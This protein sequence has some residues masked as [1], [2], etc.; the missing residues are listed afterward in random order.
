MHDFFSSLFDLSFKK[1]I[2]PKIAGILYII[3]LISSAVVALSF[4]LQVP[5]IGLIIGPVYFVVS[6]VFLRCIIEVI[7]AIFQITRYTA[8]I[9]RRGRSEESPSH[10]FEVPVEDD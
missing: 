3:G 4:I 5:A 8:E 10:D 2:A 9:A 6:I 7:L 1:F